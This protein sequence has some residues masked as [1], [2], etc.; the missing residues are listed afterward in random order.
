MTY[1]QRRGNLRW[2]PGGGAGGGT[3]RVTYN[4]LI[5]FSRIDMTYFHEIMHT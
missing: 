1:F 5:C 2:S 3:P 4:K